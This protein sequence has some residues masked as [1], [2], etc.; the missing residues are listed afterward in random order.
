M[1]A[2]RRARGSALTNGSDGW[3]ATDALLLAISAVLIVAATYE[4]A[5]AVGVI[6]LGPH[7]GQAPKGN[8]PVVLAG[9]AALLL[10]GLALFAAGVTARAAARVVQ[11]CDLAAVAFVVA[12][13]FSYDPYYAP[14]LR[15]MSDGGVIPAWWIVGLIV[16]GVVAAL[17]ARRSAASGSALSGVLFWIGALTA[18]LA[19]AG[20]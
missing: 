14:S 17:A 13:W 6:P 18:L 16:L 10:G 5:I 19:P 1:S 9:L 12:R 2:M 3:A 7:P 8:G 20:H 4:T 15:R 11:L